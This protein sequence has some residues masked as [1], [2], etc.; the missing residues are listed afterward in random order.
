MILSPR[1]FQR[2]IPSART[3]ICGSALN[4]RLGVN[5]IQYSSSEM[6]LRRGLVL[7]RQFGVAHG[8]LL[9]GRPA[10][11]AAGQRR[12]GVVLGSNP[13]SYT[14]ATG[15]RHGRAR[16]R[17]R[18]PAAHL[19]SIP[20]FPGETPCASAS[21]R[22]SRS[23]KTASASCPAACASWSRTATRSSSSTTP[24][25]ASAWT[26][27]PTA[28]PA[29]RSPATAAE[30]F[31]AADMIVKVKEPQAVERKMLRP[32]Q[33]LFTYLHLAPDP[34]QAK[35][36]VAERRRVH[37][38]RDRHLAH[39]RAAAA[40]ADVGG[41]RAAWPSRPARI[42]SRSRTAG[43]ACCWA[44]C[45]A[46]I[47]RRSWCWAAASSA[48]T[49]CHIALGMGAEVWV[50]DRSVEVLRALWRQF[51]RPLNTVFSTHD[52]IEQPRDERRPRDRRRADSRA[53][54]RRS[55]CRPRW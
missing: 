47:R 18:R 8:G 26:T 38:L 29:R 12:G 51:G 43:W 45:R 5:G 21:R 36:L 33:V 42:T 52:A 32:G 40:G 17:P 48:R 31:A 7:E 22:R 9:S 24:G 20:H 23:S 41:R 13:Q 1:S 53:R 16:R 34:E 55:S 25:R 27:T 54:R 3:T 10:V 19:A 37:R 50:L 11:A 49:R 46:S 30:V 28:R 4:S 39:R 44:A 2:Y 35:D 14:F 15:M 6:L